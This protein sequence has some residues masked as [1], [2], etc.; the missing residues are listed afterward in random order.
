MSGTAPHRIA[1]T[2]MNQVIHV[3]NRRIGIGEP[4]FVIAEIGANFG[5]LDEARRQVDAAAMAGCDA[6][7]LQTFRAD[8]LVRKGAVF[9]F[10][11]G[12]KVSQHDFFKARELSRE[13][14]VELKAH[15]ESKG[16]I[17][18]STPSHREDVDLLESLGVLLH[19]I[20]SD[21]LTNLPFIET[22]AKTGKPVILST[23]MCSL[24]EVEEAV[25]KFAATGNRNLVL[26]HCLVGY[27][28]PL[29]RANLRVINSLQQAFRI[30]I[31]FS[32]HTPGT[33][34][35][36]L[37]VA[38]G[39]C[40]IEK[41]FTLDRSAGGPDNDTSLEPGEM[42]A[43]V[44]DLRQV[45]TILGDGIKKIQ[46]GEVKWRQAARKSLVAAR[47]IRSGETISADMVAVKR[48]SDGLHPR[49]FW[50]V[51][52]MT[53]QRDVAADECLDWDVLKKARG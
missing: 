6:V 26:L 46:P 48:P 22:V 12:S 44:R 33:L 43:L 36:T 9:T 42:T 34:A 8:T 27:P 28:A 30:P 18:F 45:S 10:E 15:C 3:G 47:A 52:G 31:G 41:H 5:N 53:A 2:G 14:H 49:Y 23:G 25:S 29:E 17:F 37:A 40:V 32:D 50:D 11:D 4:A 1:D 21:D 35:A 13:A 16:M 51:L 38:Q 7:K 24:G 19:K 39:A 20:G